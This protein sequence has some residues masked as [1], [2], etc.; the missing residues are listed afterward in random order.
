MHCGQWFQFEGTSPSNGEAIVV[1]VSTEYMCMVYS[2]VIWRER[3]GGTAEMKQAPLP[4]CRCWSSEQGLWSIIDYDHTEQGVIYYRTRFMAHLPLGN[5][6]RGTI[7]REGPLLRHNNTTRYTIR[8][9]AISN[10]KPQAH[11]GRYVVKQSWRQ[12][13]LMCSLYHAA[14]M[15]ERD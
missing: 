5:Y 3:G 4:Y 11:I 10:L 2:D 13:K 8:S 12:G 6:G 1:V 14:I 9:Q 15:A 7:P